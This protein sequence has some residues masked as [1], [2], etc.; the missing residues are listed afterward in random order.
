MKFAIFALASL[1]IAQG[2][3]GTII[4]DYVTKQNTKDKNT[5]KKGESRF[6]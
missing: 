1:F 2:V 3:S 6:G 4:Q 5:S